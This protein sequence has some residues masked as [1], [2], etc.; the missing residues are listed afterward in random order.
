MYKDLYQLIN[1]GQQIP[2]NKRFSDWWDKD[3]NCISDS[4]EFSLIDHILVTPFLQEKIVDVYIFQQY[5]EFCGKYN[6]DH[7]P[8]IIELEEI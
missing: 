8:F 5:S 7:Y 1:V 3:E 2:Q 4:T 6:S